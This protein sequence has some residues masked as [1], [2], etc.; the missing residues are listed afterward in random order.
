[1]SHRLVIRCSS[2]VLLLA[3]LCSG[4][5]HAQSG[6]I[7]EAARLEKTSG[8]DDAIT[9]TPLNN[10]AAIHD[11][12]G[13]YAK[14]EPL[15]TRALA[16]R[17]KVLAPEHPDTL[18]SLNNLAGVYRAL[19]A[20]AK[21]EPLYQRALA[22]VQRTL[23]P[24][25]LTVAVMLNNLGM[26][27]ADP[28]RHGGVSD[29]LGHPRA[30]SVPLQLLLV[31]EYDITRGLWRNLDRNGFDRTIAHDT[32]GMRRALRNDDERS[33]LEFLALRAEPNR[34]AAFHDVLNLIGL[35]VRVLPDVAG[36]NR[37]GG[38]VGNHHCLGPQLR[39]GR[40]AEVARFD[41]GH[42][43][44]HGSQSGSR[45]FRPLNHVERYW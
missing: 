6:R 36:L 31:D 38:I 9:A 15:Y 32:A 35:G 3:I 21:A 22:G 43:H 17:E 7:A 10:L 20:Y 13:D 37:D 12:T 16:I 44:H 8:R 34:A 33:R 42:V 1:M 24:E 41:R 26:V 4:S 28:A 45:R 25:H 11:A 40:T 18:V 2:A 39:I 5:V 29:P 27:Y 23:G 14:S 30:M 19:G